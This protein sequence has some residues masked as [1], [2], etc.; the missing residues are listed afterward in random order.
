MK[1]AGAAGLVLATGGLGTLISGCA[2][3]KE[4]MPTLNYPSLDPTDLKNFVNPLNLPGKT[5]LLGVLEGTGK[6]LLLTAKQANLS[7]IADNQ[8]NLFVYDV[9][10]GERRYTNPII[11]MKQGDTFTA[12]LLNNLNEKTIIHWHGLHVDW[13]MDGHPS[14]AVGKGG[15]YSYNFKVQNRGGTYWYHPHPHK[16]TGRQAY[17]GLAGF[18]LVEDSD[19]ITLSNGL[20]L[21]LGETDI[22]LVIQDKRLDEKGDLVYRPNQSE[23]FMGYEGDVIFVNL[24]AN[25]LLEVS[26]RIYRFR[27]LNGSNA[28]IY[29]LAFL[30][31]TETLP[32]YVIGTDGGLLE[33][34]YGTS[35]M[36]LS[37]GERVDILLDLRDLNMDDVVVLKS[38]A[39]D[40]MHREENSGYGGHENMNM[41]TVKLASGKEFN[42]LK[43]VVRKSSR[44]D[45]R[46]PGTLSTIKP[47]D[48]SGATTRPITLSAS[49]QQ[50]LINGMTFKM[51]EYPILVNKNTTEIWEF[52]NEP[53][54][55][56]HPM[57]LHG[58]MFQVLE[59]IN[60][61]EKVKQLAVD[62]QGRQVTDLGWKD[63][64]LVWPGERVRIAID[65]THSF[66]G[67]QVLLTHCHILEHEDQGMMLNYKVF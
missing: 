5:G 47:I 44:Y 17:L 58:F 54:S 2:V 51:Y 59:R 4:K 64:V 45:K 19:D 49:G 30:K 67:E 14:Y 27:V 29:R 24:T 48:L 52:I 6:N 40:P 20:D 9:S 61:P 41:E 50:W 15:T 60:S 18:F 63:T 57:H 26:S 13:R 62:Q 33:K 8:A 23:M 11:K 34:P 21:K 7:L 37:P 43:I 3:E 1:V 42:I 55:M 16:I 65:F 46:V 31:G 38:L 36:F 22:P 66:A 12:S 32:Y 56:P 35:E 28:R 39:F 25:P 10:D 53:S